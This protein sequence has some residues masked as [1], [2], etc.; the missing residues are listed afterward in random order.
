MFNSP[1]YG[2]L[3]L[4]QVQKK[5]VSY[6]KEEPQSKYRLVIGTDSQPKN[7]HGVDFV[8]ALVVHRIGSGGIYFWKRIV[9]EKKYVLRQRIYAEAT[10]SLTAATEF[11]QTF[12][13]NGIGGYEF[14][15][16]VDVG[17][18]GETREMINEVVGMIRGSGFLVRT[19]PDSY[20][21]TKVADR[22][23]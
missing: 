16:H 7:G 6:M 18:L 8:I 20:G 22:H 3:S 10:Y 5:I 19:K 12:K 2:S 11:L 21:A 4:D 23:T 13:Q 9:Q 15:I 1:T 14:E 17:Q